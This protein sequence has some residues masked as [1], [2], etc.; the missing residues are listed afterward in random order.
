MKQK[1]ILIVR[2]DRIGDSVLSTPIP[3][4]IKKKWPESFVAVLVRNYTKDIF[5]NNPDIDEIILY[6]NLKWNGL[7]EF[8]K[9]VKVIRHFRFTHALMLLPSEKINYLLFFAGIK[10]RIGVGQKFYQF[11]TFVKNVNRHKYIPLRHEADYCMDQARKIGIETND[12]SPK[13]YLS[14][15]ERNKVKK[16]R[17]DLSAENKNIIGIN[18]TSGNS[19]PNLTENDYLHLIKKLQANINNLILITDNKVPPALQ[20]LAG[21]KYPNISSSLRNSIIHIASLD[22]LISSSTGPMHIAAALGIKTVSI[23]CPLT[24]CSP[25]LWGPLGNPHNIILPEENYCQTKC[26]GDPKICKY[27]GHAEILIEKVLQY[28]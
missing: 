18:V 15:D 9:S 11:I 6:E 24:A 14:Y 10:I 7:K 21:V 1:R 2:Q 28:L 3:G 19:A 16:I 12:F 8:V 22:C 27:N 25:E 26:P 5:L 4:E 23:F 13:I 20:N 17:D